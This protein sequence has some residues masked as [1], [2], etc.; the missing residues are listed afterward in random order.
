[1]AEKKDIFE[2]KFFKIVSPSVAFYVICAIMFISGF[3]IIY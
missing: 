3:F 1:M 2:S